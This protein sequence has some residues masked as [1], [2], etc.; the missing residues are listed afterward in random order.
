M[1][2]PQAAV[3]G[4]RRIVG[5]FSLLL[6]LATWPLWWEPA[7]AGN[8]QIPWFA[9][10]C[11]VPPWVDHTAVV[12][13]LSGSF[14]MVG[15]PLRS[16]FWRHCS[17]SMSLIGWGVLLLLDQHRVQPWAWQFVLFDVIF[18]LAGG[19]R[20]LRFWQWVI[21]SIYIYSGISKLDAAFLSSHGQLLLQGL[22][23]PMGISTAFWSEQTR[24][25]AAFLFP[26]GEILTAILLL[27]RRVRRIGLSAS[28]ALHLILIW[29]LGFSL[30]HE[31]GVVLWNL[32]FLV[33]NVW[34]FGVWSNRNADPASE[35]QPAVWNVFASRA[36]IG[37]V[38]CYPA[39]EFVGLCDHWPA[40]AVYCSRPAQLRVLIEEEAAQ[41]LPDRLKK[42]LGSPGPL[43]DRVPLRLEHWAFE[44]RDCPLYPQLRYRL[45]LGTAL[46]S[47]EV[48]DR[49]VTFEIAKTPN[50]WTGSRE[51][52]M[53]TGLWSA[54]EFE[55]RYFFNTRARR[56]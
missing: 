33:Q 51:R 19:V 35:S 4:L 34:V 21:C 25:G 40:W 10:L 1:I 54:E 37:L 56:F 52:V 31:W 38:L 17:L 2:S 3:N 28:V 36:V 7:S 5:G 24:L 42:L 22:L 32:F 6:V 26:I 45:A 27:I 50:R 13:L 53:L 43:E 14:L 9:W 46:L 48:E 12:V 41:Q 15:S 23:E 49:A 44:R 39:L 47:G 8:P 16:Q 55:A 20:G 29:V 30:G 18:L 11:R